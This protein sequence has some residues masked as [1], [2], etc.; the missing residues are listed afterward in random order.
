M[1]S[2]LESLEATPRPFLLAICRQRNIR[3]SS[4][5]RKAEL[6]G[7]LHRQLP[8]PAQLKRVG[9]SLTASEQAILQALIIAGGSLAPRHLSPNERLESARQI[10]LIRQQK[11]RPLSPVERLRLLGIIFPDKAGGRVYLPPE[12]LALLRAVP[13]LAPAAVPLA[14]APPPQQGLISAIDATI[15]DL[16]ALLAVV[17]KERPK[18]L[19][20]VWLSPRYLKEWAA[21]NV[22]PPA[23]PQ[24]RSA[25]QTE[26]RRFLHYLALQAHFLEPGQTLSLTPAAWAWLKADGLEQRQALWQAWLKPETA[27]WQTFKLQGYRWLTVPARLIADVVA[28]LPYLDDPTGLNTPL[29]H[30]LTPAQFAEVVTLLKPHLRDQVPFHL[31]DGVAEL[32]KTI[33]AL[34]LGPLL[35]LGAIARQPGQP[36]FYLSLTDQGR[37]WLGLK[38]T[39]AIP[40]AKPYQLTGQY[41]P[42]L[43]DSTLTLTPSGFP[44]QP[45]HQLLARQLGEGAGSDEG[46][47]ITATSFITALHQGWPAPGL[48]SDLAQMIGRPLAQPEKAL[49]HSWAEKSAVAVIRYL[50]VLETTDPELITRLAQTKRGRDHVV[51][52][53]SSRTVVID[54]TRVEQL[55]RR[56]TEQ[57]GVPPQVQMPTPV[58]RATGPTATA[59]LYLTWR[60]YQALGD[61]LELPTPA[62]SPL[63]PNLAQELDPINLAAIETSVAQTVANLQDALIGRVAYPAWPEAGLPV[64]ESQAVIEQALVSGAWLTLEYFALS[65]E[66]ITRRTVEPYRLEWRGDI[67]YLVGFCQR[68]QA[69]RVFRLDRVRRME[70]KDDEGKIGSILPV[71][72]LPEKIG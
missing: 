56:L 19:H 2:L 47:T 10:L 21:C 42:N 15:H 11:S 1:I 52:T 51:R 17:H 38:A 40:A 8:N 67:A 61:Y 59:Q 23:H 62:A 65:T 22:I 13:G 4:S 39:P 29:P 7:L 28:C 60:V 16:T 53:L 31:S 45:Y 32:I 3:V 33:E 55:T 25:L 50:P 35:W 71:Q 36:E 57:E 14:T 44:P 68:A 69:E 27:L 64:A 41:Q 20:R 49:L 66:T 12:I 48:I 63:Y 58:E 46:Q 18:L 6:V 5:A 37:A 43:L 70:L 24:A 34:L 54:G 9:Q 30:H 72:L 26:R